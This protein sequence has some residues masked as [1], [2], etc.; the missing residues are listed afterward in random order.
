MKSWFW[1]SLSRRVKE[2]PREFMLEFCK[3]RVIKLYKW[4]LGILSCVNRNHIFE[5]W[6]RYKFLIFSILIFC[7]SSVVLSRTRLWSI[8]TIGAWV[9]SMLFIQSS[10]A[11][12]SIDIRAGKAYR[13]PIT[14]LICLSLSKLSNL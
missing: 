14:K 3:V 9:W 6:C 5:T 8:K 10:G 11:I 7:I 2:W 4:V 1:V 12:C 13:C